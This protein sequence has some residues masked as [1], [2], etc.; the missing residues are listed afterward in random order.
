MGPPGSGPQSV[1]SGRGRHSSLTDGHPRNRCTRFACRPVT[2]ISH[3]R[4]C[5]A[6]RI[7]NK[8]DENSAFT[9][10][11]VA[12]LQNI[13]GRNAIRHLTS[14]PVRNERF[15]FIGY[16]DRYIRIECQK[17]KL[18][19][20]IVQV[21]TPSCNVLTVYR[22]QICIIHRWTQGFYIEYK[23]SLVGCFFE[24]VEDDQ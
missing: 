23:C 17:K 24:Y 13:C 10:R 21:V 16:S 11:N 4:D 6:I 18:D 2:A 19:F 22:V 5:R 1:S 9:A 3:T 7:E 20:E 15:V 12:R 8:T 14:N